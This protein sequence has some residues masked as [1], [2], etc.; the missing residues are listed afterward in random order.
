MMPV[1]VCG[2]VSPGIKPEFPRPR[3]IFGHID[4]SPGIENIHLVNI[5]IA[6][7]DHLSPH[8]LPSHTPLTHLPHTL[9]SHTPLAHSIYTLPSHSY[10]AHSPHRLFSY[11]PLAHSLRTLPSHTR[12]THSLCTLTSHRPLAHYG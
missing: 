2:W 4:N 1:C 5:L 9:A 7:N 8:T 10:L 6:A 3:H 11:T 12:L